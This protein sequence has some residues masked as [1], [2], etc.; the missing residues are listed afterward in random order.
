MKKN[1]IPLEL[2]APKYWATWLGIILLRLLAFFPYSLI[3][4]TSSLLALV[5]FK[6]AKRRKHIIETNIKICFPEKTDEEQQQL[7]L[8]AF[9]A[10]IMALF[11]TSLTWWGPTKKYIH[12]HTVEGM[13]H[14]E[15][16]TT[17]GKGVIILASHFTTLE[18]SGAF[19][20]SHID[21]LKVVYKRSNNPLL[22]WFIQHKR[23]TKCCSGLIKHKSLREVVR[24]VKKGNVV[25]F[26]PDQDFGEKDSIFAPFFGTACST[27]LSTQRLAKLTGTPVIPFFVARNPDGLTYTM[28]FSPAIENFPS[29]DDLRDATAINEAIEEQIRI[30]PA[31]YLW[32]HRRF[33]T[34]PKG[35]KDLY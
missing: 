26:S 2:Y 4:K 31:Q 17:G 1:C 25:S 13:E 22:E 34:R 29:D 7:S 35:E 28:R 5:F 16:A 15:K 11:E 18:I 10:T 12:R 27:L 30:A 19:L 21:N 20:N 33:K 3:S 23:G 14:L 8:D 6:F 32:A 9:T 24:S